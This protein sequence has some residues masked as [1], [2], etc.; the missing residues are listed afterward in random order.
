MMIM[1]TMAMVVV[2]QDVCGD[3][4]CNSATMMMAMFIVRY[5][6]DSRSDGGDG[7]GVAL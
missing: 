1:T 7:D 2:T 6:A 5:D 3:D 4:A